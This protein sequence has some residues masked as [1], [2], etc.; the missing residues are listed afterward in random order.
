MT[1]SEELVGRLS[2]GS[3]FPQYLDIFMLARGRSGF[4]TEHMGNWHGRHT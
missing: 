3:R 2:L 4:D 1:E